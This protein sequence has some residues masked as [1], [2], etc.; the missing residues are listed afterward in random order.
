LNANGKID[1]KNLPAPNFFH[2]SSIYTTNKGKVLAPTNEI[3]VIIH[4]IWCDIFQQNQISID[5][6]IF[7]IGDVT[8]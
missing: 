2:L 6:N 7:T 4:R 8:V 3:E 1:R 5:T